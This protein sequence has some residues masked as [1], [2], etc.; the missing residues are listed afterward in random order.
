[1][2]T[3]FVKQSLRENL[4]R[5]LIPHVADGLWSI[6]D[7]ALKACERNKQVDQTLRTFQNLLTRIPQWTDEILNTEVDRIVS[8]SKCEYIED[9]LLGVFVSY[10]RAFAALQQ[11]DNT[12]VDIPFDRPSVAVFIHTLYKSAAR[13]SWSNA[14]L[15]K[16]VGVSSE[17]QARSRREIESLLD[18]CLNEVIDGF[19]PW[20]SISQAYFRARES[21]PQPQPEPVAAPPAAPVTRPDTPAPNP[22]TFGAD[23]IVEFETDNE[24]EED[25]ELARRPRLTVGEEVALDTDD[26]D[27]DDASVNTE[28]ELEAKTKNAE[29]VSLNL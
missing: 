24:D 4:A 17:N 27:G 21:Q 7:N 26:I 20:R 5:V 14:Y 8:T 22:V 13:A 15:F 9:L 11:V 2:S 28:D 23:E 19:I 1:M 25:E 16:T 12:H 10:I 29:T 3:D 18:K 6:Y